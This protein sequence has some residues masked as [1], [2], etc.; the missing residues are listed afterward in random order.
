M[1]KQAFLDELRTKLAGLPP[2]DLEERLAFYGEMI[3]DR[4]EDGLSEEEAVQAVGSVEE[5]VSQ[6]IADTPLAKIA[7]EKIRPKRK[8][9]TWEIVLL[10][11]GAP[12][13]VPL[14]IAAVSVI[15]SLYVSL[16]SVV[17]S[18]WAVFGSLAAAGAGF[19]V[20]GLEAM[21][22]GYITTGM[23]VT[24][25]GLASAGLAIFTF[26]GCDA[27]TKW[28]AKLPKKFIF[29]IKKCFIGKESE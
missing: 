20:S 7:K 22:G 10:I 2:K 11:L 29:W 6:I 21:L 12:L 3:D 18:F 26:F 23:I 16:W 24:G 5:I 15:I 19:L 28:T 1:N 4:M 25:A 27:A 17:V 13:W 8:L 9:Q 14:L